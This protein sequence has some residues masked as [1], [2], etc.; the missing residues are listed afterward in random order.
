[1]G[2][3]FWSFYSV[4]SLILCPFQKLAEKGVVLEALEDFFEGNSSKSK[5]YMKNDITILNVNV[6]ELVYV[7]E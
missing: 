1:M 7:R 6:G 3:I 2:G 5:H 4:F